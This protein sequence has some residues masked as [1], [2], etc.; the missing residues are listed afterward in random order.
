MNSLTLNQ[1]TEKRA[2]ER[3]GLK[4]DDPAKRA[5]DAKETAALVKEL[6]FHDAWEAAFNPKPMRECIIEGMLR[7]GEV[8]NFIA[9]TKTGKSWFSLLLLFCVCTGRDWLKRRVARGNVLLI[10]NELHDETIENRISAVR[11]ALQIEP[12]SDY[13]KFD[14]LACRGDWVSLQDLIEGIPAKYPAGTLNLIVIDAK[15]RLFGNGLEENSNDDQT[16]FHNMIDKFA[17]AMNCP[18]VL[19]HHST[20]GDQSGKS[21]TDLGSGGGSQSRAVDLHMTIRP[22]QQPGHAVLEGAVRS[23]APVEPITLRWNWP[24]W[25]VADDVE[26]V[27]PTNAKDTERVSAMQTKVQKYLSVEWLSMSRLA[28]RCSTKKDRNPFAD[29]IDELHKSGHIEISEN[30]IP[31]NSKKE[32]TGVRLTSDKLTSDTVRGVLS[33]R[34]GLTSDRLPPRQP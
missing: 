24:V 20:K 11:W 19:V 1:T 15:Y 32:T 9:S 23:F 28:E 6:V 8:A 3:A 34:P 27:L 21:V 30:Y 5:G 31:P 12:D 16:T 4:W 25:S 17:K 22:H 26:P 29:I 33:D 7:R 10:D 2:A 13:E 18:V 14:Y